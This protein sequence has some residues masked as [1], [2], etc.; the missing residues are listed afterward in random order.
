MTDVQDQP[1]LGAFEPDQE[2]IAL[3]RPAEH[4]DFEAERLARKQRLAAGVL[5]RKHR[6]CRAQERLFF[7]SNE[8][9]VH[10]SSSTPPKATHCKEL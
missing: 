9:P 2:G 6:N 10:P 8:E 4:S 7:M 1:D 3:D 5:V